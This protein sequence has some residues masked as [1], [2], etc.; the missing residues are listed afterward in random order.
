MDRGIHL[1]TDDATSSHV[2]VRL[3]RN[4]SEK[5]RSRYPVIAIKIFAIRTHDRDFLAGLVGISIIIIAI[6]RHGSPY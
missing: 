2:R 5:F 6:P 4:L 1:G 3:C